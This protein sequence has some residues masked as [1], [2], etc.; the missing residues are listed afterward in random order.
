M[1]L[2]H[3]DSR[4]SEPFLLGTSTACTYLIRARTSGLCRH[5]PGQHHPKNRARPLAGRSRVCTTYPPTLPMEPAR[6]H[7]SMRVVR[8]FTGE[9]RQD[10]HDRAPVRATHAVVT[11]EA[12]PAA[13]G[14]VA[15]SIVAGAA[16][17]RSDRGAGA[18]LSNRVPS[19]RST[20]RNSYGAPARGAV[21]GPV[22]SQ[23]AVLARDC[24]RLARAGVDRRA[25]RKRRLGICYTM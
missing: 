25:R 6:T 7:V 20:S 12:H 19:T 9:L 24:R 3:L 10:G 14:L 22:D 2:H 15:A 4:L 16:T 18:R 23:N 13:V 11:S 8:S 17:A 1:W 21:A 5:A